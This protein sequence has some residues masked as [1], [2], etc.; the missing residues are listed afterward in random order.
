M[1]P[2]PGDNNQAIKLV[3]T[4]NV[5]YEETTSAEKMHAVE[6]FAV[7]ESGAMGITSA[8]YP[9]LSVRYP[10]SDKPPVVPS[11]DKL[12]HSAVFVKISNKEYL[13]AAC[14]K[15]GCLYLWDIESKMSKKV[16]DPELG[17]VHF[18]YMNVFN[19]N[20]N[21]VGYGDTSASS[22]GSK[23]VFILQTSIDD[24]TLTETLE[25][26]TQN[27]IWD[28]CQAK[29]QD[30]TACLLLCIPYGNRIMAVEMVGGR[31]R[32]E[33]GKEQM[34]EKFN[35]W[36]ICTDE[37]N[38]KQTIYVADHD[39]NLIHLLSAEDGSAIRSIDLRHYGIAHPFTVRVHKEYLYVEHYKNSGDRN[40]ISRFKKEF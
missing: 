33:V 3:E 15:D 19:I 29:M 9:S 7:S 38:N 13:A 36:S 21:T 25:V 37:A 28:V 17:K 18:K 4:Y 2:G 20:D 32:W 5:A 22:A 16:F 31:T 14:S 24:W 10:N 30:G 12:Y 27:N 34:G 40:F 23:R 39:Q 6:I 8:E 1:I 35:P 26:C 11:K